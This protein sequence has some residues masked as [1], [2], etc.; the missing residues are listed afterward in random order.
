MASAYGAWTPNL[1]LF[2]TFINPTSTS[3]YL[4]N[5]SFTYTSVINAAPIVFTICRQTGSTA[6]PSTTYSIWTSS[7]V[8]L[9][10]QVA[11]TTS[12]RLLNNNFLAIDPATSV[13][14]TTISITVVDTIRNSSPFVYTLWANTTAGFTTAKTFT[15]TNNF[16]NITQL[17]L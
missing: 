17:T 4:V 5:L 3:T 9:S 6:N 1:A 14:T 7:N 2:N 10:T 15:T 16:L 13:T 8:N 12:L 11:L